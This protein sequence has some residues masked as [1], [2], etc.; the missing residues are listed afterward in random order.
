VVEFIPW[1]GQESPKWIAA[2]VN[3]RSRSRTLQ[4]VGDSLAELAVEHLN[5]VAGA[6]V[7]QIE[8]KGSNAFFK[9][10]DGQVVPDS[11]RKALNEQAGTRAALNLAR[12]EVDKAKKQAERWTN[13][14]SKLPSGELEKKVTELLDVLGKTITVTLA[15]VRMKEYFEK[16]PQGRTRAD[17]VLV[18]G[19]LIDVVRELVIEPARE[20]MKH[21]KVHSPAGWMGEPVAANAATTAGKQTIIKVSAVVFVI[22]AVAVESWLMFKEREEMLDE[23]QEGVA[24]LRV[25]QGTLTIAI[26]VVTYLSALNPVVGLLSLGVV[27]GASILLDTQ[28]SKG[29]KLFLERCSFGIEKGK[30]GK[31]SWSRGEF[32]EWMHGPEG[33]ESSSARC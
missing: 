13:A 28:R 12:D 19:T 3:K 9:I 4:L 20:A 31:T 23:G 5:K 24:A 8:Y 16:A 22:A 21:A 7:V 11:I 27:L 17:Q 2:Y 30:K 6:K 29:F 26:T 14:I 32:N 18:A 33:M 1:V 15:L 10:A 25:V